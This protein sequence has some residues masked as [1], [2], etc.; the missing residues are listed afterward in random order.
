MGESDLVIGAGVIGSRVAQLLAERGRSRQRGQPP[1]RRACRGRARGRGRGGRWGDGPPGRGG[2]RHLQLRQ[3][4]LSPLA[5]RLAADRRQPARRRGTQRRGAGHAVQ[6]V[7][8]RPRGAIPGR[9]AYDARASDDRGHAAGRDRAARAGSGPASGR[10]RWPRTRP[11]GSGWPRSAP[12]ISSAPARRARWASGSSGGSARARASRCSA[13]P[14][15]RTP[16]RSPTTW[17]GCWWWRA[18]TPGPGD[19]PGTCRRTSR[20]ASARSSTTSPR[21]PG[22]VRSA[23]A[24]LPPALLRG[25]GLVWPL[26]RELRETEYQF[27]GRLRHGFLGRQATFGLKPT[28][29]DEVVAVPAGP[30]SRPGSGRNPSR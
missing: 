10:T 1:W 9:A 4:A 11:D 17:P 3:P 18:P 26:M 22:S 29:W 13:A 15:G 27:R 16:G 23:S 24:R 28:P 7:R 19:G 20:A 30:A 2:R 5:G 14:T 12:P 21:P 6:P 25:M 8:L